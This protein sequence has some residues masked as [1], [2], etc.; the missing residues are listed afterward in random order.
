MGNIVVKSF[1]ARR[2]ML[3]GMRIAVGVVIDT[4]GPRGKVFAYNNGTNTILSK[5]GVTALKKIKLSDELKDMGVKFVTEASDKAN[6]HNGDGSSTTAILTYA[7]CKA[8]NGLIDQGFDINLIRTCMTE[9]RDFIFKLLSNFKCDIDDEKQIHDIAFI[10]ANGD[11][12]MANLITQA[13]TS[14]GDKGLV[15]YADSQSRYGESSLVLSKGCEIGK[16]YISSKCVNSANDQCILEDVYV[17]IFRDPVED[18][19]HFKM[20]IQLMHGHNLLVIAPDYS[21]EVAAFYTNTAAKDNNVFI[22]TPGYS[23]ESIQR[24]NEDL[25]VIFN[26]EV[27]G[28]KI[29]LEEMSYDKCGHAES[30][31]ATKNN[32]VVTEPSTDKNRK[33]DYVDTLQGLIDHQ[34]P[35]H[36]LSSDEITN[37]KSR[38]AKLEGGIATIYVGA[39]SNQELSERKDRVDDAL[40]AVR[41]AL[42]GGFVVGGGTTLYRIAEG[43]EYSKLLENTTSDKKVVYDALMQ[44]IKMPLKI[45]VH[46][47]SCSYEKVAIELHEDKNFGFNARTGKVENLIEQG[48][49]DP[50]NIVKNA[51]LYATN[52]TTQFVSV[53]DAII[54][55]VKN[56]SIEPLDEVID[57]GRSVFGELM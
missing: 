26:T 12:E 24:E 35:T 41:N 13:F 30:I 46:S 39:L 33:K 3:E 40:N 1:D 16:G 47:A 38:I 18:L 49:V 21:D 17:A 54:S 20:F 55:D 36:A 23:R 50:Y 45:L 2:A 22:R 43:D 7:M 10:S 32:V 51:V 31:I 57:P 56:L 28:E 53:A 9:I 6:Y 14:I 34:D 27:I 8:M 5:D 29:Q 15:S 19:E 25:A 11:E 52:M 48:I 42:N 4:F 37:I 44:A